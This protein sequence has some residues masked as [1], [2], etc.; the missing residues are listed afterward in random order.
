MDHLPKRHMMCAHVGSFA[1]L[2]CIIVIVWQ[3][4]P[5]TLVFLLFG[6]NKINHLINHL[7][8]DESSDST[9]DVAVI[10]S[11]NKVTDQILR[12]WQPFIPLKLSYGD[13]CR[14]EQLN[15]WSQQHI[16][17]TVEDSV[18]RT[19]IVGLESQ[20]EDAPKRILFFK[21]MSWLGQ[22]RSHRRDET[23][24]ASL[25]QTC[26]STSMGAQI[27]VIVEKPL[28]T[29]V[30]RNFQLDPLG[31]HLNTCT[32]TRVS[33]RH[34]TGWLIKL[35]TFSVRHIKSKHNRSL[36]VGDS[37][38][39]TSSSRDTLRMRRARCIWC[40]ISVS[41]MTVSEVPLTLVLME[42]YTTLIT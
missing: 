30:W 12:D 5:L 31:D 14:V 34:T 35:L 27:P 28:A 16:V 10:P 24:P 33:K 6:C 20:E 37:I 41:P 1:G 32:T 18:H 3:F 15:L 38:V 7:I 42:T 36:K 23:W 29:C 13:S 2:L 8:C 11:Q 9:S 21:P 25:W 26:F 39:E 40:W 19:E 22:I 17:V 4:S